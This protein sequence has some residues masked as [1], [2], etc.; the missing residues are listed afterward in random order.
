MC[1]HKQRK[2]GNNHTNNL[3]KFHDLNNQG[4]TTNNYF[5]FVNVIR[6]ITLAEYNTNHT[7]NDHQ[8]GG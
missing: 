8:E 6:E 1:E 3:L 5:I 4:L 7:V 2:R